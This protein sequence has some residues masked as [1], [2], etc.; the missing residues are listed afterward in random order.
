MSLKRIA[1]A[2]LIIGY[3][4]AVWLFWVTLFPTPE[5]RAFHHPPLTV[6]QKQRV[7]AAVKKHG[8]YTIIREGNT[9]TMIREG[10]EIR[11]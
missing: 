10:R 3:A 7:R 4:Y 1:Y 9:F 8:D 2:L 11:L 5:V 6:E